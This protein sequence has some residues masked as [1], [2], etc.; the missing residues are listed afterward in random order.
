M[1]SGVF[2][3]NRRFE[4]SRVLCASGTDYARFIIDT[5]SLAMLMLIVYLTDVCPRTIAVLIIFD[6]IRSLSLIYNLLTWCCPLETS[7]GCASFELN[8]ISFFS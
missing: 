8:L 5:T 6:L 7:N 3:A 4:S 2:P 1:V